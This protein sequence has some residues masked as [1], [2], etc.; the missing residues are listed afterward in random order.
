M[1][2]TN[3]NESLF[4]L[5]L[6]LNMLFVVYCICVKQPQDKGRKENDNSAKCSL[7][8]SLIVHV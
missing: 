5:I 8:G 7:P 1:L 3:S 4:D 6:L 2:A